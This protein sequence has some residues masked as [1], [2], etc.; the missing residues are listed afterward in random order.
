MALLG[1]GEIFGGQFIGLVKDKVNKRFA[2][3]LQIL[4]TVA[5]FAFVFI[6]NE[7]DIYDYMSFIMAFVWGLMDSGLNAII[8]S[9]LGFE[10]ESKIVPFSVFNF[11]QALFI[12]A[13]QLIE[14]QVTT[15]DDEIATLRLYL[16]IVAAIAFISYVIMLFFKYK[17][18]E[19]SDDE[20]DMGDVAKY[21]GIKDLD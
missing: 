13:A 4:L 20:N 11:L 12:F 2:L 9:M 8:R 19:E 17:D 16:I 3:F 6:V 10:F 1:L 21:K 18:G 5:A 14:G 7:K 15:A